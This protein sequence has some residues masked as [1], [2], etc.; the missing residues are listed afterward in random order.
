M[1][2][3]YKQHAC[4]QIKLLQLAG[5]ETIPILQLVDS[6]VCLASV[7]YWMFMTMLMSGTMKQ[8]I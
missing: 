2:I 1:I 8:M 4:M 6:I 5:L 3:V 7:C